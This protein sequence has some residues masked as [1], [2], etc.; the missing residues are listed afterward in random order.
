MN[1]ELEK[2]SLKLNIAGRVYPLTVNVAEV[3]DLK[4]AE[5]SL[6]QC[7]QM[8]QKSYAVRDKQDLLAM[9]ALQ[10]SALASKKSEVRVEKVVE[11]VVER[12][13]VPAEPSEELLSLEARLDELLRS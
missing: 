3:D 4:R 10:V 8:F 13:E 9:A 5:A 11:R 7:L 12:I 1:Q 2:V 6:E